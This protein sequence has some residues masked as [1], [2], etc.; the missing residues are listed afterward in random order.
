VDLKLALTTAKHL[1][2]TVEWF[3]ITVATFM[4]DFWIRLYYGVCFI[5]LPPRPTARPPSTYPPLRYAYPEISAHLKKISSKA[6]KTSLHGFLRLCRCAKANDLIH[7]L[8]GKR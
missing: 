1:F 7:T 3:G 2:S 4:V 5:H 6:V 8:M